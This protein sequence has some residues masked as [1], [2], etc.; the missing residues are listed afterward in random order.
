MDRLTPFSSDQLYWAPGALRRDPKNRRLYAS[1]VFTSRDWLEPVMDLLKALKLPATEIEAVGT[2]GEV[3]SISFGSNPARQAWRRRG[4]AAAGAVC[5]GL[6]VI[7][8]VLPFFIQNKAWRQ[9]EAEISARRPQVTEANALRQRIASS[10]GSADVVANERARLR[11][12]VRTLAAL[13]EILPDDTFLTDLK[14]SQGTLNITGQSH[15]AAR[16]IAALAVDPLFADPAFVAP[17]TR[18]EDGRADLFSIRV[19]L[20][21]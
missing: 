3:R 16:L 10:R 4:L 13:T 9:V 6:A 8:M 18:T 2:D 19:E 5:A 1:V 21:P 17:V 12:P 14:L 7:A 15:M 11:N 20:R